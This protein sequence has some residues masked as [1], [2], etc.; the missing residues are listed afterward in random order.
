MLSIALNYE[1]G[2]VLLYSNGNFYDTIY[3]VDSVK[4][5]PIKKNFNPAA[6]DDLEVRVSKAGYESVRAATK[7]PSKVAITKSTITPVAYFDETG[8][9]S[10][11]AKPN[12][13]RPSQ[14]D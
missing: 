4:T 14:R 10:I 11:R 9:G 12:L 1:R 6:G 5:Y 3:Y 13:Q 7:I 2:L 8:G